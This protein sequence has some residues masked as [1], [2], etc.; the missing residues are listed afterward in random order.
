MIP[1]TIDRHS[2]FLPTRFSD[3]ITH[4]FLADDAAVATSIQIV[5]EDVAF[6]VLDLSRVV[7]RWTSS[8]SMNEPSRAV[9]IS[10]WRE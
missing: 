9:E 7:M 6:V 8:W 10:F 4:V 5:L 1:P 3:A 2:P